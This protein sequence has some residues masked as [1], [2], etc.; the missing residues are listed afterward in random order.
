MKNVKN[1]VQ[2]DEIHRKYVRI[3]GKMKILKFVGI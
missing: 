1:E 2:N 3:C